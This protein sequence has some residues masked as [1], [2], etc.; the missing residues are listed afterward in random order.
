MKSIKAR[1]LRGPN[2]WSVSPVFENSLELDEATIAGAADTVRRL[3]ATLS[4][5]NSHVPELPPAE[6]D[7]AALVQTAG[8]IAQ[9]LQGEIDG[10]V[11]SVVW[12]RPGTQERVFQ[13]AMPYHCEELADAAF[14]AALEICRLG[15]T[16]RTSVIDEAI[17]RLREIRGALKR[18]PAVDAWLKVAR[19]RGIPAAVLQA[20]IGLVQ[21]GHGAKQRRVLGWRSDL[22]GA[23]AESVAEDEPLA[24]S[25]IETARIPRPTSTDFP[26]FRLLVAR[27]RI[28]GVA[29]ADEILR[30]ETIHPDIATHATDAARVVGLDPA[31]V[32]VETRDLRIP[33]NAEG[34]GVRAVRIPDDWPEPNGYTHA[35]LDALFPDAEA[36]R[37][38][39]LV[40]TG[41]NGKTTVT[42][43]LAHLLEANG[44]LVGMTCTEGVFIDG[45]RIESGDCSGPKSAR[46]VFQNR[47]VQA[48]VLETARGGILRE[49]LAMD[50]VDVA[51]VTNIGAGDHLGLNGVETIHDLARVKRVVVDC[52]RPAS[53]AVLNAADPLVAA[54]ASACSGRVVFFARD[55]KLPVIAG[56]LA[57]GGAAAFVSDGDLVFA[58]GA[59]RTR[60]LAMDRVPLTHRSHIPFQIEN[61]LAAA[62]AAWASGVPLDAIREGLRSFTPTF[63]YLPG[64]FNL[65]EL[66]GATI[67]V[68]YGHNESALAALLE[69]LRQFPNADRTCV[70]SAAGD[71]RDGDII[72]QGEILSHE[73]DCVIL[74]EDQY[75]RGR[76]PGEIT[77][78][79]RESLEQPGV[80]TEEIECHRSWELALECAVKRLRPGDLLLLQADDIETSVDSIRRQIL[81][82]KE[83]GARETTFSHAVQ[84]RATPNQAQ[85]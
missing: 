66:N 77:R 41:V 27:G 20:D 13:L 61:A 70:Y 53:S 58:E 24:C 46:K 65:L 3:T 49:G 12:I 22:T 25:L 50:I 62:A 39:V 10:R 1:F 42:R 69:A 83:N 18:H 75:R 85:S 9:A 28:A 11:E 5:L 52:L 23:V 19:E 48:A 64:R 6:S 38:P 35:A 56:H 82:R 74:Y 67:V 72:R 17:S 21:L 43:L 32:I 71:R 59:Q 55:E 76:E 2:I 16:G 30:V 14:A 31:E 57:R 36:A 26:A 4:R 15:I 8:K 33:L 81:G 29:K 78:L 68:D 37:I 63:D 44:K 34:G 7:A 60:L 47:R 51:V 73:F 80:R 54:M 40:V 45:R 79:F 84:Q